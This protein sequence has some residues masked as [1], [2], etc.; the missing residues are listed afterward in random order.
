[1]SLVPYGLRVRIAHARAGLERGLRSVV[2]GGRPT[3][4]RRPNRLPWFD[5]PDAL[6]RIDRQAPDA[7][8]LERWVRDG[9]V[10]APDLVD[11]ADVDGM[12]VAL[13]R[14]W[15]ATE[16]LPGLE[17]LDL[18]DAPGAPP[19]NVSHAELLRI[20]PA[21]RRPMREASNW[22]I[23]GFHYVNDHARRLYHAPELRAL[24]S[25]ILG[26]PAQ[27]IASINFMVGSAQ[28]LHQDMAVFHIYPHNHLVG[29]W[30][31]CEDIA[32]DS[33]PLVLCSGSHRAP[34]FPGFTEYPQTNLRT[35][36]PET[37]RGYREYVDALATRYPRYEFLGRAGET[38]LWHGMLLH[39]GAP[40][41]RPGTTRKSLVIHYTVR[42]AD[43]GRE[44]RGPFNW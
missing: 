17:L 31:A 37:A 33:G 6:E 24:V 18:R 20:E 1:M 35:A 26:A 32:G 5:Q 2:H 30:I 40:V 16:P 34:L 10:V 14:L 25:R 21:R 15:D 29:A 19:H 42:G 12:V 44:V 38:L 23:H 3:W 9:W 7:P 11:R 36:D 41:T 39:G 8:L 4:H 43:R 28:A 13:D 27:P 22:R